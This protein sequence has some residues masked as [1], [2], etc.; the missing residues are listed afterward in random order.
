MFQGPNISRT[1]IYRAI[2]PLEEEMPCLN[3]PKSRKSR[4]L[5]VFNAIGKCKTKS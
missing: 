1:T 4:I 3:V 5:T 2:R